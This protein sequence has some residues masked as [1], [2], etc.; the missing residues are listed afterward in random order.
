M[1]LIG[2]GNYEKNINHFTKLLK[3]QKRALTD[4]KILERMKCRSGTGGF[5]SAEIERINMLLTI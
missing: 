3:H 2:D 4:Q 5:Y 1:K